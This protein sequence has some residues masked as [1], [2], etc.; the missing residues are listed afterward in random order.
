MHSVLAKPI[1][2]KKITNQTGIPVFWNWRQA[3]KT[4]GIRSWQSGML[5]LTSWMVSRVLRF[6][7]IQTGE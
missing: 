7:R 6:D 4:I 3:H 5:L 2:P 1:D